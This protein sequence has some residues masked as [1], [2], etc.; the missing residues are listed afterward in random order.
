MCMG[1]PKVDNSA[2]QAAAE[3]RK[4]A[5]QEKREAEKIKRTETESSRKRASRTQS[6]ISFNPGSGGRSF[7]QPTG[8]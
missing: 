5:E 8:Q 2:A 1:A 3:E 4:R 6:M 7:F